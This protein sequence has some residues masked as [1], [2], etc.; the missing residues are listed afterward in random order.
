MS[1]RS[2]ILDGIEATL[3]AE[4]CISTVKYFGS[5]DNYANSQLDTAG[6]PRL[7]GEESVALD[8]I[9]RP[10]AESFQRR[11]TTVDR[12]WPSF[13]MGWNHELIYY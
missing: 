8:D 7:T 1:E 13:F 11:R 12:G 6:L 2:D 4:E 10:A 5:P 9:Y 3:T